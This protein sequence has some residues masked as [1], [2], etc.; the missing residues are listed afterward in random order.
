LYENGCEGLICEFDYILL[1][2]WVRDRRTSRTGKGEEEDEEET[3]R[4]NKKN[5]LCAD[6]YGSENS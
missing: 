1:S 2:E 5:C 3:G 4:D 6:E